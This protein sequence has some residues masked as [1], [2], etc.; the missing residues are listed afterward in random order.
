MTQIPP[1]PPVP[2]APAP[3]PVAGSV[4]GRIRMLTGVTAAALAL[5]F[6][7]VAAG[8]ATAGDG[9]R[10]IGRDAGPQVVATSGL[11]FGLSD[12]DSLVADVLVMDAGDETRRAQ[13]LARYEQQR[14][15][16]DQALLEAF[17]LAG[18]DQAERR[19]IQSVLDGLG[20]YERLVAQALLLDSQARH[21]AGPPSDEVVRVYR[22]ATDLM[23]QVLLP[24]AY[25]LTLES[26]TIVRR[27]YDETAGMLPLLRFAVLVA[28]LLAL[29]CL[30]Y[31]QV[32]LARRFRRVLGPALLAATLLTAIATVT[33]LNVLQQDLDHLR[34]AKSEGFDSVVT[35]A[36]ARAIGNSMQGDQSRFLL[37]KERADTY[38]HRF[39]DKSQ[40]LLYQ[41]GGNLTAYQAAVSQKADDYRGMLGQQLSGQSGELAIDAYTRYQAADSRMRRLA[42][43]NRT[44]DAV[45]ARLGPVRQ[46]FDEYDSALVALAERHQQVFRSAV[47]DGEGALNGLWRLLP[48]GAAGIGVLLAL[49]VWPR[50]R[51]YR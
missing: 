32:Y 40:R 39:L 35:L 19:T 42:A 28:G 44:A 50:L 6:A 45:T 15:A 9:L 33:G 29:A 38:Q 31:L 25:N 12:M 51:E 41:E 34:T 2:S 1:A 37:D 18:D 21:P 5:L 7:A 13:A 47:G 3:R 10:L 48:F 20:R 49:G 36:R 16:A 27:T 14:T 22:D 43:Q 26:G 46:A 17:E 30:V 23:R 4:P 8:A 11:Y 24:Q